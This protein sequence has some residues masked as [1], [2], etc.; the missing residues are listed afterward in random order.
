MAKKHKKTGVENLRG[1]QY[2]LTSDKEMR[3]C[4]SGQS[5][6]T[7]NLAPIGLR[8]FESC[9]AHTR[10]CKNCEQE[11]SIEEFYQTYGYIRYECKQCENKKRQAWRI[12]HAHEF[13]RR[14]IEYLGGKCKRCGYCKSPYALEFNHLKGFI[15]EYEPTRLLYM[16]LNWDRVK[17]ELDKCELL[18]ANCH[19]EV[20]FGDMAQ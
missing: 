20:T 18:C 16:G 2:N 15:K 19:R 11:K 13:K 8:R 4:R 12:K 14:A 9:P 10:I 1:T 6:E 3:R 7:V 5:I 17:K